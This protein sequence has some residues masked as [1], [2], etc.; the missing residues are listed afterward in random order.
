MLV[1]LATYQPALNTP[2]V[3]RALED[4]YLAAFADFGTPE[5]LRA[6]LALAAPLSFIDMALRYRSQPPSMVRLH[7]WMRDLVPQTVKLALEE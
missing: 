4:A 5:Q 7:P 3:R 6:A 2:A 1:G